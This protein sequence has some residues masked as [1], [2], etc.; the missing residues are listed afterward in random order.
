[1]ATERNE[2]L[3]SAFIAKIGNGY[4]PEQFVFLDESVKD[5]QTL[6]HRYGY[7]Y[8][9]TKAQSKV[10]FVRGK[11]YTILPALTIDGIVAVKVIEES[12]NKKK[13][14]DFIYTQ[15][16]HMNLFPSKNSV[17]VMDNARIHHNAE[18]I[19]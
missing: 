11:H 7:S 17:L 10:M 13:F 4:V 9:G 12:Y 5:E 19:S 18:W 16:P 6:S 15:I 14:E 1:M 2:L 3:R 8:V